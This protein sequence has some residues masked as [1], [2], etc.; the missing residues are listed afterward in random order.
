MLIS[1]WC[2]STK[3]N[4]PAADTYCAPAADFQ[5]P[6][7]AGVQYQNAAD[8]FRELEQAARSIL[9]QLLTAPLEE[10]TFPEGEE[11]VFHKRKGLTTVQVSYDTKKKVYT[12]Q[13]PPYQLKPGDTIRV[14]LGDFSLHYCWYS[15][16]NKYIRINKGNKQPNTT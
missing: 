16:R 12:T 7:M 15:D 3:N 11:P 9:E 13:H 1:K 6:T 8:Q 2:E 4:T 5:H 14:N 10:V